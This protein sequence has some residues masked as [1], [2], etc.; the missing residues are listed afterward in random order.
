MEG[1]RGQWPEEA[2]WLREASLGHGD[3]GFIDIHSPEKHLL[4]LYVNNVEGRE[5]EARK[6]A[7]CLKEREGW[8]F[9]LWRSG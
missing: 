2:A 4:S 3:M 9:L 8:E 1:K 5:P 6:C 7:S